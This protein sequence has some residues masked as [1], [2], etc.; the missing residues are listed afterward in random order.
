[1]TDT[2]PTVLHPNTGKVRLA[3][4]GADGFEQV[5]V[6][7]FADYGVTFQLQ[8]VRIPEKL[9]YLNIK[10]V[11]ALADQGAYAMLLHLLGR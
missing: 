9:P 8:V 1:M 5:S 10:V 6:K 3:G 2:A 7:R 4:D 11:Q